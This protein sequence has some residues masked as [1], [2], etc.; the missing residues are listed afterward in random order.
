[1][2][3]IASVSGK[4]H[5]SAHHLLQPARPAVKRALALGSL[6]IAGCS[7]G[8]RSA[9]GQ[10]GESAS[11][12]SASI[13]GSSVSGGDSGSTSSSG[14]AG[15]GN[16]TPGGDSPVSGLPMLATPGGVTQPAGAAGGLKVLPW[17]GFSA[18][19]S[20]TFDDAQPSHIAH[21]RELDAEG[22]RATFYL[23]TLAQSSEPGFDATWQAA[24]AK[25]WELGNHTVHHCYANGMC[26]NGAT[27]STLDAELDDVTAYIKSTG[28]QADV[29]TAAYPFGDVGYEPAA[30]P[31]F[32]LAR[33]TTGGMVAPEDDTDPYDLPCIA[34][35]AEGGEPA[36][37]FSA[38]VDTARASGKWLIFL[39]HS[40]APTTASWYATTDITSIT[41]SIEHAKSLGDVWLDSLVNVGAYWL[42]Q[43]LL[44]A[45]TP[46][47]VAGVTTWS[48]TLPAHFPPGKYL[49]AT[50]TGGSLT[51]AGHELVWG[52]HGYYEVSLDAGSLTLSGG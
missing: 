46:S 15:M 2:R 3:H 43:K 11:A 7:S 27:F 41:G 39:F 21:W 31:R 51:Q 32:L 20:Y 23:N 35:V 29:W 47:T 49:R 6:L 8:T 22:I 38:N 13:A 14:S 42:G 45:A 17:A 5:M 34:A 10:G 16:A 30:K 44:A 26:S 19:V 24:A 12:G 18:A 40:I 36:S 50:V 28:H 37:V 52:D 1:M 25:G 9:T 33:G 48:W 4:A